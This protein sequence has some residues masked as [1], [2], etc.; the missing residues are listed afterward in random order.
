MQQSRNLLR[1]LH[2]PGPRVEELVADQLV[3]AAIAPQGVV[4]IFAAAGL[5][6]PDISGLGILSD[7]FLAEVRDMPQRNLAL[8]LLRK[9]LNDE[10]G[11]TRKTGVACRWG[12]Q[13]GGPASMVFGLD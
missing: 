12:W 3:D 11:A 4:D 1:G 2:D 10:I 7:Q 9:L 5:E 6:K 8:E 13:T